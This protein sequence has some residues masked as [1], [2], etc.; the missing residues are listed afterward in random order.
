MHVH[1]A[2]PVTAFSSINKPRYTSLKKKNKN[3]NIYLRV[4]VR[5]A[6]TARAMKLEGWELVT[7]SDEPVQAGTLRQLVVF[8]CL[9]PFDILV[10]LDVIFLLAG[11]DAG[12]PVL[13]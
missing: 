10:L 9:L 11:G 3:E 12:M 7:A 2:T 4:S 5:A 6:S 1:R 8:R 13:V